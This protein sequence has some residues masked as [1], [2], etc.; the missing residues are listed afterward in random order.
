M[1]KTHILHKNNWNILSEENDK[2]DFIIKDNNTVDLTKIYFS[3]SG[4]ARLKI[5]YLENGTTK[6]NPFTDP[7]DDSPIIV[8]TTNG[9]L[10]IAEYNDG[11]YKFDGNG[12]HKFRFKV[13][14]LEFRENRVDLVVIGD[15][16]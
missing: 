16:T 10:T 14:N 2:K 11:L 3:S 8:L 7:V 6:K 15:E 1:T 13:K 4:K 9:I 12:K 5:F